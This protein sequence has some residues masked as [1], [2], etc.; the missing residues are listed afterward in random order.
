MSL[1]SCQRYKPC[2]EQEFPLIPFRECQQSC[3][4]NQSLHVLLRVP[5]VA[6]FDSATNCLAAS[7]TFRHASISSPRSNA[8]ISSPFFPRE[9][10]NIIVLDCLHE[11]QG[12]ALP[13]HA[14]WEARG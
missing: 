8:T 10:K 6:I 11:R 4:S 12:F 2:K 9:R 5:A 1:A 14:H 13:T 7:Q 3:T